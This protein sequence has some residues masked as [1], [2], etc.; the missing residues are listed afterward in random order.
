MEEKIISLIF[1][2]RKYNGT[3]EE[4]VS[5]SIENG[6]PVVYVMGDTYKGNTYDEALDKAI[7]TIQEWI[8]EEKAS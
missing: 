5:F 1:L 3:L 4:D 8:E 2:A 6:Y 7:K